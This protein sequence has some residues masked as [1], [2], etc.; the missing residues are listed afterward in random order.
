MDSEERKLDFEELTKEDWDDLLQGSKLLTYQKED[1]I[2]SEGQNFQ[3]IYQIVEGKCRVEKG[4]TFLSRIGSGATLGEVSFL[5]SGGASASVIAETVVK[6]QVLEG[7]FM[8]ILFNHKPQL[9]GKFFKYLAFQL[10]RRIEERENQTEEEKSEK[11][12]Q[13][14]VDHSTLKAMYQEWEDNFDK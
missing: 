14:P 13:V 3:R 9:G 11:P 2:I 8:N 4:N 6:A 12:V 1:I 10:K 5:L 7:Y